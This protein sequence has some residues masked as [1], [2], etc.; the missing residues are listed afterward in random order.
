M[1]AT[2]RIPR[3]RPRLFEAGPAPGDLKILRAVWCGREDSNLHGLPRQ[4]LKLVR[5]P[6]PPRP[7][8]ERMPAARPDIEVAAM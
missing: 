4:H 5:L 2:V 3:K 1:L 8:L 7:Q 6:I